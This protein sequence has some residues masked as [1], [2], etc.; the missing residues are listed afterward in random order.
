MI[1][2]PAHLKPAQP[3]ALH[4]ART[5]GCPLA[6]EV[7]QAKRDI[8]NNEE[9]I[10]LTRFFWEMADSAAEDQES[11]AEIAGVT[12][13]QHWMEKL[14]NLMIGYCKERGYFEQWTDESNRINS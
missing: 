14:M 13:L 12:D 2:F 9:A 8:S 5:L 7:L 11:G 1:D 3:V 6:E 10:E 4:Y